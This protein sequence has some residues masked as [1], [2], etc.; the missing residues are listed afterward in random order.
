MSKLGSRCQYFVRPSLFSSAVLIEF[1]RASQVATGVLFLSSMTT[2]RSWWMLETL[3]SSTFCLRMPHRCSRGFRSEYIL[4][5]SIIF[6]PSFFSKAVF[7]IMLEYCPVAQSPKGGDHALLQ[8][9]TVHV[10]IHGSLN[11][12]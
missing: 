3:R 7:I 11:E 2:S 12:L 6:T 10:G 9:V 8:Y 5:Q 1:T 4:G